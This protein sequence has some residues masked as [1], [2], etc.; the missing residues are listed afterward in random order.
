MLSVPARRHRRSIGPALAVLAC[1]AG[2]AVCG[3]AYAIA[4]DPPKIGVNTPPPADVLTPLPDGVR[5]VRED[6][7]CAPSQPDTP[8]PCWRALDVVADGQSGP[9]TV[10]RL[11]RSYTDRGYGLTAA[12]DATGNVYWSGTWNRCNGTLVISQPMYL[13]PDQAAQGTVQIYALRPTP[14]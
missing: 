4:G 13:G 11:G 10:T 12:V 7:G 2:L 9:D 5:V 3:V 1:V 6:A 14:C 8:P